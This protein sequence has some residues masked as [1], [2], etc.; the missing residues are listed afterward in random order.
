MGRVDAWKK[1]LCSVGERWHSGSTEDCVRGFSFWLEC[2]WSK[3][4]YV[5]P[6]AH[7]AFGLDS[8]PRPRAVN[9]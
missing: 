2:G 1:A 5:V 9:W 7:G 3:G 4:V 8:R 6:T